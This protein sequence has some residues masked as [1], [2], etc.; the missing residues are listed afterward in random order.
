MIERRLLKQKEI[1]KN[2]NNLFSGPIIFT[3]TVRLNPQ[4]YGWNSRVPFSLSNFQSSK[5]QQRQIQL[6]T[7]IF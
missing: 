1:G 7:V 6:F 5:Y 4:A 3:L 2:V